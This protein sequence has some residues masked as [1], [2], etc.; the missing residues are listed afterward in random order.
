[1]KS[2]RK[3]LIVFLFSVLVP[4]PSSC[5]ADLFDPEEP[6]VD[7]L[8]VFEISDGFADIYEKLDS[9]KWA[10]KDLRVAIESLEKLHPNAHIAVTD[11]RAVLVWKDSIVGNWPKPADRDWKGYGE[12]TTSIVLKLR[13]VIPEL[14]ALSDSALYSTVVGLLLSG[15]D[16]NGRYIYSRKA[17]I[18]EDG[19]LVTSAGIEGVHDEQ[20]NFRITGI[21]KGSVADN[22]G[23][24]DGDLVFEI[25]GRA[26]SGLSSGEIA[27]ELAGFNSGTV[28]MSVGD[29]IGKTRTVILRRASIMMADADV[30]VKDPILE[31]VVHR[32]SDNAVS[33]VNEALTR[34]AAAVTG[35]IL[36]LRA[37]T[38]ED[39]RA[40]AKIAG[41]FMGRVPV[42]RIVE[43]AFDESEVI[44][45]GDATVPGDLSVVVLTSSGTRGTAEAL[46]AAFYENQR[47]V[48]IGTP[49]AGRA[50]LA[51]QIDLK[52]GGGLELFNREAKTGM[53]RKIDGRGIFPLVCLSNIR[54]TQQRN[55]FFVN[56]INGD[57][58]AKDLNKDDSVD[59]AAV[60]K[61]CPQITSGQDE[62]AVAAAVSAQVLT[63]DKR[64]YS[65]LMTGEK[66]N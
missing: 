42:L 40:A 59:A 1:M 54:N 26:T 66:R 11:D 41:L 55:A 9:V 47:G 44:P 2:I 49:T 10:G 46:A 36:D 28:K 58:N 51:T 57:F 5:P 48:L 3:Y 20:G 21:Y 61:G 45:G 7:G 32:V 8:S 24:K 33:I 53:G 35:I 50:R 25:N 12:I 62:D 39:E 31:I 52:N 23:I 63:G 13:Q 15:V 6:V 27:S 29:A 17:E 19:R 14:R 56:V 60:R 34:Y 37:A 64:I 22:V 43:T 4:L 38:G 16:E 30:I 65:S 18:A